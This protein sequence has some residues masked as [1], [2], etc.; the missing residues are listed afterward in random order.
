MSEAN[1]PE[2]HRFDTEVHQLLKLMVN[3]L[4]SNREIFLRELIS[5]ASD[6]SD[7]LRFEAL[8]NEV[9]KGADQDLAI[10]VRF[11][12]K[13]GTL[14]V[15]D[16]G[17]GMNREEVIDNLGTIARS[18][19]RQFLESLSGDK[20]KDAALIGQFGVGF[21]SAF[22]VASEVTV[23]TR[24]ADDSADNGVRWVST[25]E[26]EYQIEAIRRDEQG[27]TITLTLHDD[28]KDLLSDW[29]LKRIIR[30]YSNH[31]AFPIRLAE[32]G[33]D[34]EPETVNDSKALWARAKS[35]V[36]DEEYQEFYTSLTGDE[37]KPLSWAHHHVEGSQR[38]SMLLYLPSQAPFD[39]LINRDEREGVKLYIQRVFI[40]DAAEQVVPRYLR[41]IRGVIDSADLPLNISRE[42]LQDNPLVRKI[43]ATVIKRSLDLIEKLAGEGGE[44]WE[45]FHKAFGSVLKE[46][47]IEDFEQRERI[48]SLLRFA[49][50]KSDDESVGLDS[51]VENMV[52][53][54]DTIWYLTAD[55]LKVA[56][57]SPHLE[58]F[59]KRGIE[60]LLLTDRID[61]WLVAHLH[62]YKGKQLKSAAS[63]KLDLE[64][65]Q[66]E[67]DESAKQLAGRIKKALGE[68][69]GNVTAGS[70]LTDSPGCIVSD[71]DAMSLQM[72]KMLRQ[73]GQE[74]PETKPD[75]EINAAH[76][77][78]ETMAAADDDSRFSELSQLLFDQ[79]LL[80][81]GGELADPAAYV[82]RV[83]SLLVDAL[84]KNGEN[85]DDHAAS[86]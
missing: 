34:D 1:A 16:R 62:E 57:N 30:H 74:V 7:K 33:K 78:L 82:K 37:E 2:T 9:L 52:E 61:E 68:Q 38:Y 67:P 53:G 79:A 50:S 83:N 63:G 18:G 32:A 5:N 43:R 19:T 31:I 10:D 45:K 84:G 86:A 77:L 3:A 76:P 80:A 72:Q 47:V 54:Q 35:E 23:E 81:E 20:Q 51:Y 24:R 71:D 12:S 15:S 36:S 17:I 48:A 64:D 55:S 85:D 4:Y 56:K 22:I 59:R 8:T 70:R 39:M 27:T 46:G 6:A 25:G 44:A 28:H 73:A 14:T 65:D 21:Y 26:G 41:F 60:V 75:L 66:A 42:I 58:V 69:V 40:M 11:D 49:S 13:A 29:Q